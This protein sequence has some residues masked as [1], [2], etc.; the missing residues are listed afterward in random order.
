MG[1]TVV[2]APTIVVVVLSI[3]RNQFLDEFF[4]ILH[5]AGFVLDGGQRGSGTR[6]EERHYS[7][8][9]LLRCDMFKNLGGDVDDVAEAGS[10]L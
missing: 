10:L 5:E 7:A 1:K 6:D 3:R 2:V 8:V 9:N 4:K